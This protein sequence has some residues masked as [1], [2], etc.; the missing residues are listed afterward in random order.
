M[1]D[2]NRLDFWE[3]ESILD[4]EDDATLAAIDE[5]IQAADED[6]VVPIDEVR[7]RVRQWLSKSSSPKA[8]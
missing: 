4:D 1:A 2:P 8:H 6:R 5:G 3:P 7:E